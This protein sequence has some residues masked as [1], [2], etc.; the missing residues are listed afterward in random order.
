M[1]RKKREIQ[2]EKAFGWQMRILMI[3]GF[4]ITIFL[5]LLSNPYVNQDPQEGRNI[6]SIMFF[7]L[8]FWAFL[9]GLFSLILSWLRSR[10]ADERKMIANSQSIS[11][12]QGLLLGLMVIVVLALQSFRVLVWWDGMLAIGA[13]FMIELYFLTR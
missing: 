2:K 12:R 3:V 7:Y 10:V 6:G 13:V 1:R 9:T 11:L 8:A 5:I 4:V